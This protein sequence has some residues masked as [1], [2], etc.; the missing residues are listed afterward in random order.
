MRREIETLFVARDNLA[1]V[2]SI[3][4]VQK[5][6]AITRRVQ[7][8]YLEMTQLTLIRALY[9]ACMEWKCEKQVTFCSSD[10]LLKSHSFKV[11]FCSSHILFKWHS[12]QVIF[13]WSHIL[14]KSHSVQ[15]ISVQV[16][17]CW[18]HILL[19]SHSVQVTFY[20]SD[21][22]FKWYSVKVTFF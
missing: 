21:I 22:L 15:V 3:N 16:T 2:L 7:Q 11:T 8:I 18:S 12:V 1:C 10:V 5:K 20:S 19:K 6:P 9:I 13:C 17:F 14:L 4:V